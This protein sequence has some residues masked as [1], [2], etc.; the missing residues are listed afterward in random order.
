MLRNED[1]AWRS[2]R[3]AVKYYKGTPVKIAD[4]STTGIPDSVLFFNGMTIWVELKYKRKPNV[5]EQASAKQLTT[6]RMIKN[7]GADFAFVVYYDP[8]DECW[9]VVETFD[10]KSHRIKSE[11]RFNSAIDVIYNLLSTCG[12]LSKRPQ[13]RRTYESTERTD[14]IFGQ[15]QPT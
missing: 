3:I 11:V 12:D 1:S 8:K 14:M 13:D 2:L 10:V 6:I 5:L 7:H 4:K 9:W 15:F